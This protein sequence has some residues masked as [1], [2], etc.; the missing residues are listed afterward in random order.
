MKHLP[1]VV[2]V[3]I[4]L[5][6]GICLAPAA[7]G[8]AKPASQPV[9][10]KLRVGVYLNQPFAY[11]TKEDCQGFCVDLWKE[12]AADLN[13]PFEYVFFPD[14]NALLQA[15]SE[16]KIDVGI[17]NISITGERLKKVDFS[18]P[19]LQGGLQ[20]MV[21][22]KRESDTFHRLWQGLQDSGHLKIFGFAIGSILLSTLLLTIAER[23]WNGEFHPDWINGLAESFYHVM[24]ITMTGKSSHKGL[25]G[26]F[27]KI[28]AAVW[29]AFGVGVVAY[30][31]SSVTSVMTVNRLH[32]II[33][34]PQDLP[35]HHIGAI[36]GTI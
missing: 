7:R 1:M 21:D 11:R 30:I 19:Y 22:E 6:S 18:H 27:G 26:P 36:G 29:L 25:P 15:T 24:S 28:L 9:L 16:G 33:N 8:E 31:T 2:C 32:G 17:G 13:H 23:R 10:T 5:L 20:V 34:G 4:F 35:G 12:I 14:L 3:L